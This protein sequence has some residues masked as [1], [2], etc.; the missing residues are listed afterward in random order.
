MGLS[1]ECPGP[2]QQEIGRK[3][4]KEPGVPPHPGLSQIF[5]WGGGEETPYCVAQE[6]LAL[7]HPKSEGLHAL[8]QA[9][10]G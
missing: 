8:K 7:Q 5:F 6:A 10:N 3:A 4:R 9:S 2:G 1:S